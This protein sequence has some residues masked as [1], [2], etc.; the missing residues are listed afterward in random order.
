MPTEHWNIVNNKGADVFNIEFSGY[1][2]DVDVIPHKSGLYCVYRCVHNLQSKTVDI[3]EL[4]YI[5]QAENL[6][7]RMKNHEKI[8]SWK[9]E[10]LIGEK[11]CY[12]YASVNIE[13]LNRSESALIYINKPKCNIQGKDAFLYLDTRVILTGATALLSCDEIAEQTK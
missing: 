10:L 13:N 4:L 9:S 2:I 8:P 6:F 11:L 5:G 7:N 12:S 3:K 1:Y